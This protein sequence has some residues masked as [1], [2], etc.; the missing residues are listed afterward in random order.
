MSGTDSN[1]TQAAPTTSPRL[2][3]GYVVPMVAYT[4]LTAFEGWEG[5]GAPYPVLYLLKAVIVTV[6]LVITRKVWKD[7]RFD[8]KMLL[9]GLGVG[10]L[11]YIGWIYV[12]R[13]TPHFRFLGVRTGYDPIHQIHN[14]VLRFGFLA[15]RFYGMV[16]MVPVMEELFWRS[17]LLRWITDSD[18]ERL[19]PGEY[20]WSAFAIVAGVFA[21]SHPEWLAA[22]L[23]A[24]A[25]ALLLRRTGSLFACIVAH[26]TTN[27]LLGL[28]VIHTGSWYL[29]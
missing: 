29:W 19:K 8:R 25:M 16:L 10:V 13:Y 23:F 5:S 28:Y 22:A 2:W 11:A 21:L 20:S 18:F 27:L 14:S 24:T 17:F 15:V 26:G 7:I 3:I 4:A 6:I 9:L 1:G 12:D